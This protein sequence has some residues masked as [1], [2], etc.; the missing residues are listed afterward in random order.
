MGW[1]ASTIATC[2]FVATLGDPQLDRVRDGAGEKDPKSSS[3][4]KTERGAEA[5]G[6]AIRALASIASALGEAPDFASFPWAAGRREGMRAAARPQLVVPL[7]PTHRIATPAGSVVD[8]FEVDAESPAVAPAPRPLPHASAG[9]T[10]RVSMRAGLDGAWQ[11]G[12]LWRGRLGFE[13]D[14]SARVGVAAHLYLF[15]SPSSR[16]HLLLGDV[17]LHVMIG[18]WRHLLLRTGAG[19]DVLRSTNPGFTALGG[20]WNIS[21]DVFVVRPLV[22]SFDLAVGRIGHAVYVGGRATIGVAIRRFEVFAGYEHKMIGAPGIG[23]PLAGV[24]VWF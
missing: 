13:L 4:A 1:L 12:G 19:F 23:G 2:G 7:D 10:P 14:T 9:R 6:A 5:A 22:L 17:R 21:G 11:Y 8:P 16:D 24:R 3:A 20:D 18:N 15:G